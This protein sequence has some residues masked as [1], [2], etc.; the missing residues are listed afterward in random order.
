[1]FHFHFNFLNGFFSFHLTILVVVV[2]SLFFC[3][4]A[5]LA[6]LVS[7]RPSFYFYD[8]HSNAISFDP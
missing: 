4:V 7:C 1:M 6:Q 5:K 3:H 2:V 8:N